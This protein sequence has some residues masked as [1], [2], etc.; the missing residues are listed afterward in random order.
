M[1]FI[2]E[3]PS[4]SPEFKVSCA[5]TPYTWTVSMDKASYAPGDI[6]TVTITAKDKNGSSVYDPYDTNNTGT[7]PDTFSFVGGDGTTAP[8]IAGSNLTAVVA[9][10]ATDYF[11]GGS[12]KY[13]F[14]VGSTE[15]SYQL[16]ATLGGISTDV[17]K[18]VA[19]SIKSSSTA[20]SNADVLKAIVSL[21]A[22]INK[23]IAAL[24]KALLKK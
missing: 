10:T 16:T 13:T 7:V 15:G 12:K 19:Y 21:I 22:S 23:Q 3:L 17:S 4:Y 14:V 8:A 6:A 5:N 2:T 20:V 11:V 18:T 1:Q 9:P 24:Q